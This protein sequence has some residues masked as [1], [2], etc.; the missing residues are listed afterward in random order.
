MGQ[1]QVRSL[2]ADAG[3]RSQAADVLARAFGD[4]PIAR[5]IEP[6]PVRRAPA[7]RAVFDALLASAA[8]IATIHVTSDPISSVA[9]WLPPTGSG[10]EE[11][12]LLASLSLPDPGQ[13]ERCR[14]GIG[15]LDEIHGAVFGEPHWY[16]IFLGVHP[17]AQGSGV[18]TA[19]LE[20]MHAQADAS[21]LACCLEAF[22]TA[23]R[24]FYARRGY[25]LVRTSS[26]AFT[27]DPVSSM[28]RMPRQA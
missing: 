2:P 13:L 16:L 9:I 23:N 15:A 12:D 26:V 5:Y 27:T 14:A 4:D 21:G 25:D 22:G 11:T 7:V 24:T 8:P 17:R 10:G 18:G 20:T 1:W 28:R 19:L 3:S 6:D